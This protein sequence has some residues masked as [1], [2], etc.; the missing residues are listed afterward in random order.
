[1]WGLI[2]FNDTL[3]GTRRTHHEASESFRTRV[4]GDGG[5][6]MTSLARIMLFVPALVAGWF[7]SKD[8]PRFWV[9]AMV[10]ALLFLAMTC[11]LAIYFPALRPFAARA[12]Q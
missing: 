2:K 12:K 1:M 5:P 7:V 8:D 6:D 9:V 3:A 4:I 10:V 11:V